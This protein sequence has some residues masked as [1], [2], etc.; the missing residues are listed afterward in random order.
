MPSKRHFRK[1]DVLPLVAKW[2]E[3]L[4]LHDW[5]ITVEVKRLNRDEDGVAH[6]QASHEYKECTLRFNPYQ[7]QKQD[8]ERVVVHELVH[9]ILWG[10]A[11]TAG[12][13]A[14][15]NAKHLEWV[16]VEEE[17]ATVHLERVFCAL[18]GVR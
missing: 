18:F 4:G 7:I 8:L 2:R 6:N 10:L 1:A 13:L 11:H 12:T 15:K 14:G 5:A 17:T 16:R 9:S 3:R